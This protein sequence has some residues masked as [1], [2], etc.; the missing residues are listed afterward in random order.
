MLLVLLIPASL[1]AK[2]MNITL[3]AEQ[4]SEVE[5]D[6]RT[7]IDKC[8]N[9]VGL[10]IDAGKL[11]DGF[12]NYLQDK[13]DRLDNLPDYC[14]ELSKYSGSR[15]IQQSCILN[16]PFPNDTVKIKK[17]MKYITFNSTYSNLPLK[18]KL[19]GVYNF[20]KGDNEVLLIGFSMYNPN[21]LTTKLLNISYDMTAEGKN[22]GSNTFSGSQSNA[23]NCQNCAYDIEPLS[24]RDF[25]DTVFIPIQSWSIDKPYYLNGT[26]SYEVGSVRIM[27]KQ[28]KF[29]FNITSAY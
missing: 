21:V 12:V 27:N 26:Y 25:P 3:T 20:S 4:I 15:S 18:L 6:P 29:N 19:K 24:T 28:F 10:K 13:C 5:K 17:C 1:Y 9:R 16:P 11:C 2:N 8:N 14:N 23:S 22:I 7:M